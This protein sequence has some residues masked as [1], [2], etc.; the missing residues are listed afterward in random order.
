MTK[1][2]AE[3]A[4]SA[5]HLEQKPGEFARRIW[6][7]EARSLAIAVRR[8]TRAWRC[9]QRAREDFVFET[10]QERKSALPSVASM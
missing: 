8:F 3:V 7:G 2:V 4:D 6:A 5:T 1:D 9:L 10:A